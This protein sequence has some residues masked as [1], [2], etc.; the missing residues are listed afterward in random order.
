MKMFKGA[1]APVLM[2]LAGMTS[3]P[4]QV[5]CDTDVC[6]DDVCC[7][8]P[9]GCDGG[10]M[11]ELSGFGSIFDDFTMDPYTYV[12]DECSGL[13]VKA[14]MQIRHRFHDEDN[15]LRPAGQN[16]TDY[17]LW[18]V[19]PTVDLI[20]DYGQ[21]HFEGIDASQ[22]GE[23]IPALT[24]DVNRADVLELWAGVNTYDDLFGGKGQF[25]YGRQTLLYGDQHLLSPLEWANTRRNFEGFKFVHTGADLNVDAFAMNTLNGGAGSGRGPG[26]DPVAFDSANEQLWISGVYATYTGYK[27]ANVDMY[28]LYL[29][30]EELGANRAQR[31][32]GF[33]FT[34]GTRLNGKI[35]VKDCCGEV[36]RTW[37]WNT[38]FMHQFGRDDGVIRAAPGA[39]LV[40]ADAL[41]VNAIGISAYGGLT[42]NQVAWKPRLGGLFWLGSGTSAADRA[43]GQNGT[44]DTLFPLG[45]K[46]WGIIDNFSGENLINYSAQVSVSPTKKL[47]VFAHYHWFFRQSEDDFIYNIAG[48][49]LGGPAIVNNGES[50]IGNELDIVATYKFNK[51]LSVQ[52][53]WARFFY[54]DSVGAV[55]AQA[56]ND[57]DFVYL[58]TQYQF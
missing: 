51:N 1:W 23:D 9:I 37:D 46:Y 22:F 29:D 11:G 55:L 18:R 52:L 21:V 16:A 35:P 6:C 20:S 33:R 47:S 4:A 58:Q 19:R 3:A 26:F 7:D 2:G 39:G 48:V 27:A 43:E 38:E 5:C 57:G 54:D 32:G 25:R 42:F 30:E 34:I 8:G 45:H 49:G 14:G 31:S 50:A 17:Q 41:D 40:T 28:L 36:V 56:A 24:I 15:R 12:I 53:G 13:K 44:L 10:K